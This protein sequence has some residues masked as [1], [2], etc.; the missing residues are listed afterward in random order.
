MTSENLCPFCQAG[1]TEPLIPSE[2][3]RV[4]PGQLHPHPQSR[5]CA[6]RRFPCGDGTVEAVAW[7]PS[8]VG[9]W[10][11]EPPHILIGHRLNVDRAI[12][13]ERPRASISHE[14]LAEA[15]LEL[16]TTR[17]DCRIWHYE[18]REIEQG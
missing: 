6:L 7:D 16:V 10:N 8:P 11:S 9:E 15:G 5:M 1:I 4:S 13:I 17:T 2:E 3:T 14:Q 18:F 12:Y